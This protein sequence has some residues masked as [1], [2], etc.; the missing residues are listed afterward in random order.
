MFF[1]DVC[2]GRWWH[3]A[4]AVSFP[5]LTIFLFRYSN[6]QHVIPLVWRHGGD[7]GELVRQLWVKAPT[8]R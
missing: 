7:V 3:N 2:A 8:G 6:R 4:K 1:G 5:G